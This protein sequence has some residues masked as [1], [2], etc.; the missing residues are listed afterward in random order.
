MLTDYDD[1][2]YI[3]EQPCPVCGD[4]DNEELLL[5]CDGCDT[6]YHT[7]CLGLEDVPI[8]HWFC[9]TCDTQRAIESVC[10]NGSS[11]PVQRPRNMSDRR[12]RGQQRRVRNRN[13]ASSSNWARVW[14][15]VWDNLNLDL[16][17]PFDEGSDAA[18]LDRAQRAAS[19]RRDIEVW[20]RRFAIAERQGG[21]N[22]F[23]DTASALLDLQAAR[24]RPEPLEAE[25]REEIRAWN[26]FE[27]AKEIELD[28][29]SR[30]KRKSATSSPSEAE[31]AAQSERPLKR[32]RTRRTIDQP[33]S[34]S[35]AARTTSGSRRG[36]G[37]GPSLARYSNVHNNTAQNN[38]P[39][40]LQSMLKEIEGSQAPDETKGQAHF[41]MQ[42]AVNYSSPQ[43]SSPGV[44]PTT[45]SY[46]S[47]RARSTTPPPSLSTR[48]GSP[49]SLTS[50]VEP[51]Y[52]PPEFSPDWSPHDS[53]LAY[54]PSNDIRQS[55]K[56][57]RASRPTTQGSS[58]PRS[59]DTSPSRNM[60]LST[61]SDLQKMV[62][63]ALKPHYP[64]VV[65]KDQYTDINRNVS[66]LLYD[67]FGENGSIND[68]ARK[69][70]ERLAHNEVAKAI[71]S[72]QAST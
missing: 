14:Q 10:P 2:E 59:N 24:E 38:G 58:P 36:S 40:F 46:A 63:T 50:K 68:D 53:N 56:D 18:Q 32:P 69:N 4:G 29:S 39:S 6:Y 28:P 41:S 42:N 43:P 64:H 71:Q 30:R 11:R 26:A 7:Y 34:S 33:E 15:S 19:Q 27:K 65:S 51:I 47:P 55:I 44:S 3:T 54:R 12:T 20:E 22:R 66:R 5:Q 49:L 21:G 25:S 60:P 62:T 35:N 70:W 52:P 17:F 23:R 13:Q 37:A 45:S 1:D 9:E 48:P 61:K 72:L 16:D 8:G 67:K 31:P 57:R